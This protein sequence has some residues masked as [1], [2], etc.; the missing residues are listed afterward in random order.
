L[1]QVGLWRTAA[2]LVR[3]SAVANA[4]QSNAWP[5]ATVGKRSQLGWLL[6]DETVRVR[7]W[8][9]RL[10]TSLRCSSWCVV[11]HHVIAAGAAS[12]GGGSPAGS[13][14][15]AAAATE[16]VAALPSLPPRAAMLT[17]PSRA[18]MLTEPY[19]GESNDGGAKPVKK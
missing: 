1:L 9:P 16:T 13:T 6:P 4:A 2:A 10:A 15:T 12:K 18:A 3:H 8:C 14:T 17:E 7:G 19:T 11:R 5:D